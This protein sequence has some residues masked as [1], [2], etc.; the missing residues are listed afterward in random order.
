VAS[1]RN[2][3]FTT[4]LGVV[5]TVAAVRPT[6]A[7]AQAGAAEADDAQADDAQADA[8][9]GMPPTATCQI[10]GSRE[11]GEFS[12]RPQGRCIGCGALERQRMLAS[13]QADVIADGAGRRAVEV[14]PLNRRVFGEFLRDRG[15]S[16]TSIDQSRRGNANDPRAVDFIDLEADL[17]DLSPLASDSIGLILAQH[18]IEEIPEYDLALAEIARILAVDGTALLEIPFESGRER[19]ERKDADRFGNVWRFGADL[20]GL[21]RRF[22]GVVEVVDLA[23]G[24]YSGSLLVCRMGS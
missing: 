6:L 14:G 13:S 24:A 20:P 4:A 2:I 12:G 18:V 16:Y 22:F 1:E 19:S 7:Q 5:A 3:W 15:W 17:R 9:N 8:E 10:C 11:F 23:E 21:V